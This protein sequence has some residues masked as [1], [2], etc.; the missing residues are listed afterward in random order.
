MVKDKGVKR[1]LDGRWRFEFSDK[2]SK[3]DSKFVSN[4]FISKVVNDASKKYETKLQNVLKHDKLFEHY[5]E[6]KEFKVVFATSKYDGLEDADGYSD[7]NEIAL[8]VD[9]LKKEKNEKARL[10]R[11]RRTLLHEV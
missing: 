3:I 10:S 7:F 4:A 11:I 2:E 6:L 9:S 5:P 1:G 8:N